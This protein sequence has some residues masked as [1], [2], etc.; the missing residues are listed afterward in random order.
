MKK[1]LIY[2][3]TNKIH[4]TNNFIAYSLILLIFILAFI[5]GYIIK[6]NYKILGNIIVGICFT[7][8]I[9]IV[10]FKIFFLHIFYK[11]LKG[12]I[13]DY[14]ELGENEIIVAGEKYLLEDI[15]EMEIWNFDFK[16]DIDY[17]YSYDRRY[18]FNGLKSNGIENQ[19]KIILKNK[20]LVEINFQQDIINQITNSSNELKN[21][22]FKGK[23]SFENLAR[24][25]RYTDNDSKDIF[26]KTLTANSGLKLL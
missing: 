24:I 7:I 23:L 2:R 21:Y 1:Y 12:K 4:I 13:E 22:Y 17:K 16:D 10:F 9:G 6:E 26:K 15:K 25:F 20:E 5:K 14:I 18:N 11:P 8:C 19:F 3:E